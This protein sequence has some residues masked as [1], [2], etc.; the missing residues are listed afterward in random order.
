MSSIPPDDSPNT[1]PSPSQPDPSSSIPVLSQDERIKRRQLLLKKQKESAAAS[2]TT[3]STDN[4]SSHASPSSAPP[5]VPPSQQQKQ[6]SSSS[7]TPINSESPSQSSTSTSA[8]PPS[9]TSPNTTPASSPPPHVNRKELVSKAIQF[10][11]SPNVQSRPQSQRVQFLKSKGL[12]MEEIE[13][14]MSQV[15]TPAPLTSDPPTH[16]PPPP[17]TGAPAVTPIH[18]QPALQSPN[19]Q[20]HPIMQAPL[21]IQKSVSVGRTIIA[22]L[23]TGGVTV[24]ST[25]I[26]VKNLILPYLQSISEPLKSFFV[27]RNSITQKLVTLLTPHIQLLTSPIPPHSNAA[28]SSSSS[29]QI[30]SPATPTISSFVATLA[31]LNTAVSNLNASLSTFKATQTDALSTL[32]DLH[33]SLSTLTTSSELDNYYNTY[34]SSGFKLFSVDVLEGVKDLVEKCKSESRMVKNLIVTRKLYVR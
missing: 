22:I 6:Q 18:R 7:S 5:S 21:P 19:P 17:S 23:L 20:H 34:T 4:N 12:T 29:T 10:L 2:A 14:A 32:T 1:P 31:T 3:T 25:F 8:N 16:R 24:A 9:I 30:V 11:S 13:E 26:L 27:T 15:K 28:E 33:D